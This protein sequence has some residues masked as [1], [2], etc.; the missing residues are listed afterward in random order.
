VSDYLGDQH[1]TKIFLK[2]DLGRIK[3]EESHLY[4]YRGKKI[5]PGID[6]VIFLGESYSVTGGFDSLEKG[7]HGLELLLTP[8]DLLTPL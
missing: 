3:K 5:S 7:F 6:R 4:T 8:R 1:I 2:N